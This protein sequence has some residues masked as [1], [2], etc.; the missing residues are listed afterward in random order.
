MTLD[1]TLDITLD[2][3][4]QYGLARRHQSSVKLFGP[5]HLVKLVVPDMTCVVT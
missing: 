1:M 2:M 3:A 4:F 5:L